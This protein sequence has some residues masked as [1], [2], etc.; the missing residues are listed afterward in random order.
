MRSRII[1]ATTHMTHRRRS[2]NSLQTTTKY[3]Y[4]L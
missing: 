1:T 4:T 2:Q 3:I